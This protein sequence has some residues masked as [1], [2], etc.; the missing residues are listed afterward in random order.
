MNYLITYCDNLPLLQTWLEANI[1]GNENHIYHC[2][3]GFS[4]DYAEYVFIFMQKANTLKNE[5]ED[6]TLSFI[7]APDDVLALLESSTIEILG[8]STDQQSAYDAVLNNPD[9]LAKYRNIISEDRQEQE[10]GGDF[11]FCRI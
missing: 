1:V 7:V 6:K 5:D 2:R 4:R 3:D 9:A 10:F 11:E 8:Q